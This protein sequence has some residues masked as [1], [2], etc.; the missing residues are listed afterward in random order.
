[1]GLWMALFPTFE[2]RL[3]LEVFFIKL[4]LFTLCMP[5]LRCAFLLSPPSGRMLFPAILHL[6]G[7]TL[8]ICPKTTKFGGSSQGIYH[9]LL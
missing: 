3:V 8:S 6:L 5:S 1:M 9:Y 4:L 7:L 2:T